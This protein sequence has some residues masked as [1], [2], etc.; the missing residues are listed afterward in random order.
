MWCIRVFIGVTSYCEASRC[1][2]EAADYTDHA[3]F[4]AQSA[5]ENSTRV[6]DMLWIRGFI[7]TILVPAVIGFVLPL[8]GASDATLPAGIWSAGW[9]LVI[10]GT[11]GYALCLL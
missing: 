9:L 7:F 4:S 10:L 5:A 2:S 6:E 8:Y 11:L 3:G 1:Q